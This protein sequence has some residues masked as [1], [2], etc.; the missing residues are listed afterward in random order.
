MIQQINDLTIK[1][2]DGS[3]RS[4][5]R[6]DH[7]TESKDARSSGSLKNNGENAQ[8]QNGAQGFDDIP[9]VLSKPVSFEVTVMTTFISNT[10]LEVSFGDGESEFYRVLPYPLL[11]LEDVPDLGRQR[12]ARPLAPI[13]GYNVRN[14]CRATVIL[15]HSYKTKGS[16]R[17]NVSASVVTNFERFKIGP[18]QTGQKIRVMGRPNLASIEGIDERAVKSGEMIQL[19]ANGLQGSD[20]T[21]ITFSWRFLCFS[22]VDV[23][24]TSSA[25]R[26][27]LAPDVIGSPD[28]FELVDAIKNI[29]FSSFEEAFIDFSFSG[30]GLCEVEVKAEN[31]V[32]SSTKVIEVLVESTIEVE[33]ISCSSVSPRDGIQNISQE[34][35]SI[36]FEQGSK[37]SCL[38]IGLKGS[39][40]SIHWNLCKSPSAGLPQGSSGQL[41]SSKESQDDTDRCRGWQGSFQFQHIFL[42]P[43]D[44]TLSAELKNRVSNWSWPLGRSLKVLVTVGGM[45]LVYF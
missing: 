6:E 30:P 45:L 41:D 43:G 20:F 35:E 36:Q 22:F 21:G 33:E 12:T 24:A 8:S 40:V 9:V 44:W 1:V 39:S 11:G 19:R 37:I 23:H 38:V 10:V 42:E 5:K 27:E 15:T 26:S 7:E 4:T 2:L 18:F 14:G 13:G 31:E 29:T 25:G 34:S 3:G 32:G 16:F 17:A 28:G